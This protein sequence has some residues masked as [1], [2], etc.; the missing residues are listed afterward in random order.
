MLRNIDQ[1]CRAIQA[2]HE[3]GNIEA[4]KRF[5]GALTKRYFTAMESAKSFGYIGVGCITF[6][7]NR[8]MEYQRR[9]AVKAV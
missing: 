9:L 8:L 1:V 5:L 7:E 6:A 3:A 2:A 4:H